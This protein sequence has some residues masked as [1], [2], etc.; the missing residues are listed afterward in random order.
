[1]SQIGIVGVGLMGTAMAKNFASAGLDVGLWTRSGISDD[2]AAD[3]GGTGYASLDA[4]VA[5]S[6][7]LVLSLF[8]DQA[9][10]DVLGQ[11]SALDLTGRLIVE[12]STVMPDVI[13]ELAPML[14]AKGAQ[15][16][17][18]P[19]SG[20][21]EMVTAAKAGIFVG[22]TPE[23]FTRVEPM[24]SHVAG[25]VS[26]V[27]PLG[28]G[29]GTKIVINMMLQGYWSI[30]VDAVKV[31]RKLGLPLEQTMNIMKSGPAAMGMFVGRVPRILGED[32]SVGFRIEGAAKDADVFNQTAK[33]L[34][35]D[36]PA[37]DVA[38]QMF[39][40]ALEEGQGDE[41]VA[42]II[43]KAYAQAE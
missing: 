30:L 35:L 5:A 10:R 29:I 42:A 15:V 27:G 32:T 24:L 7:V 9:V 40:Q 1:M 18:A 4:L 31:A 43:S 37:L 13:Q 38:Q 28:A 6:D 16:I 11:L 25:S 14:Q 17:D 23:A 8:D 33:S 2:R 20:G 39:Q 36:T 34:G 19:I 21:P 3:I 22:G 41:D 12:T 26:H